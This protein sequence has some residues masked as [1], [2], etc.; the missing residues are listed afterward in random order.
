MDPDLQV[1]RDR[2]DVDQGGAQ[3]FSGASNITARDITVQNAG[4]DMINNIVVNPAPI[5]G[6]EASIEEVTAWLKG[7][8]FRAIY[9]LSLETRMD[10]T[11][12]W[13]IATFEFGEFVRQKGRVVWA[14]GLPGSGK[15]ILASIS[16]EHLEVRFSGRS[17]V[18]ILYAFLRYSEKPTFL[19]IIAGLLTQYIKMSS[20]AQKQSNF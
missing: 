3:F 10:D 1:A 5:S 9:R 6:P 11:G 19:Q 15:T 8:N 4:R 18:A 2:M 12:T 14:T 17:D 16:I 7:A 13:F 20:H